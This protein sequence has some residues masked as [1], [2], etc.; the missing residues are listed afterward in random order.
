VAGGAGWGWVAGL[1]ARAG[2]WLGLGWAS[3][4]STVVC[5]LGK[6]IRTDSP[7]F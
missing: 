4:Q 3:G 2:L 6:M 1:A 7:L 5:S